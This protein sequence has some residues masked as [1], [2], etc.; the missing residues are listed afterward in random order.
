MSLAFTIA[1]EPERRWWL[2]FTAL[3]QGCVFPRG[4][5]RVLGSA[6]LDH[7]KAGCQ[8]RRRMSR[9]EAVPWQRM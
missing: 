3:R 8:T 5:A 4:P 2:M 6:C 1:S 7:P 9:R